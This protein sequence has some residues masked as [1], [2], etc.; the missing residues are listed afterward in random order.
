MI[1]HFT[2]TIRLTV[3]ACAGE[4]EVY[5]AWLLLDLCT[6]E[7]AGAP[8]GDLRHSMY[9]MHQPLVVGRNL[10]LWV[11]R[12]LRAGGSRCLHTR[13]NCLQKMHHDKRP[14]TGTVICLASGQWSATYVMGNKWGCNQCRTHLNWVFHFCCCDGIFICLEGLGYSCEPP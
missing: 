1:T 4:Q 8:R 12:R 7:G 3:G 6:G 14:T 11:R 13:I 10:H 2:R 5:F 9:G